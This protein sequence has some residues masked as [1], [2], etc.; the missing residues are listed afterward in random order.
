MGEIGDATMRED[1]NLVKVGGSCK[2]LVKQLL[3]H[4][5]STWMVASGTPAAAKAEAPP[6]PPPNSKWMCVNG[7]GMPKTATLGKKIN[8]EEK[9]V[10]LKIANWTFE[11]GEIAE[12]KIANGQN[13][14]Y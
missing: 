8:L 13:Y 12:L 14:Y 11:I 1:N 10:E 5:P 4:L 2:Y 6:P 7:V 3:A 9:N